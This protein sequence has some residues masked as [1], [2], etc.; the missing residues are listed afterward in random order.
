MHMRKFFTLLFL[1]TSLLYAQAQEASIQSPVEEQKT[2][3]QCLRFNAFGGWSALTSGLESLV[4]NDYNNYKEDLESG[5]HL[6]VDAGYYFNKMMGFG[7]NYHYFKTEN[8]LDDVTVGAL[9][10]NMKDAISIHYVGPYISC[11]LLSPSSRNMAYLNL[12]IGY[13]NYRDEA[14]FTNKYSITGET[15]GASVGLGYDVAVSNNIA[16]GFELFY[17]AGTL[18]EYDMHDGTTTTTVKLDEDNYA[19]LNRLDLS[20]GLRYIIR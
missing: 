3:Y 4:S 15:V 20:I 13:L 18:T 16:I 5:Y 17:V 14:E 19:H 2:D 8:A 12:G 11:R 10:G 6:G 9:T 1:T 7:V